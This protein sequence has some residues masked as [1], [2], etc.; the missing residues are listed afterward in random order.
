MNI[1]VGCDHAG[2][3]LK[4]QIKGWLEQLNHRV[5]DEGT[6]SADSADYPDF[7]ARVAQAVSEGRVERG[8]LICGTGIG[9]AMVANK[10][11][12]VRAAVCHNLETARMSRRH[13]DANILT[14][15]AR[16]LDSEL[17]L[18]IVKI[19]DTAF[20]GGRHERRLNKIEALETETEPRRLEGVAKNFSP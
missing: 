4:E 18:D 11:R 1:S 2:F 7:G 19:L 17:A 6:H 3:E 14:L 20:D 15:G 13:N 16:I 5:T 12:S 9:M 10:F 8:I